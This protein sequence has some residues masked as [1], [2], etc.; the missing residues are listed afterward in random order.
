M[1][2]TLEKD[3]KE[4]FEK[5]VQP[6]VVYAN[7]LTIK[8]SEDSAGAQST[9]K[10]LKRRRAVVHEKFDPAVRAAHQAW[11]AAKDLY[12]FF[13]NPFDEAETLIKRKV[14]TF[15]SEQERKRQEEAR[16]AEARRLDAERKERERIAEQARKAEEAGKLEKAEALREKAENH[17]TAPVFAPP[18][19]PK[20]Q[21]SV[22]KK[23]WKGELVDMVAL[24]KAIGEGKASPNMVMVNQTA[25]NGHAK[26]N[27]DGWPLPGVIFKEE[28]EM[29]VRI[30]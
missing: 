19:A 13:V 23:V 27:K 9:L 4:V 3:Q 5:E 25:I 1:E 12:N 8:N 22:F 18:A 26:A 21:G 17:V 14:V 24:C 30:R 15:E 2:M 16:L 6:I 10:E 7:D 11:K 29:G 20:V 28:T